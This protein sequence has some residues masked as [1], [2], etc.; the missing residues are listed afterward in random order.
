MRRRAA[1]YSIIRK[2]ITNDNSAE[3]IMKT[4]LLFLLC[5]VL[6]FMLLPSRADSCA[7]GC[8]VF[9]VGTRWMMVTSPGPRIFVQ[10]S[11]LDQ[12]QN[13][14]NRQQVSPDLNADKLIRTSFYTLGM[15]YMLN[16]EWGFMVETQLW[17]RYRE[18]LDD[19]DKPFTVR[20]VALG[21]TRLMAMYTG[22]SEDMSTGFSAGIKLPTGPINQTLLDRDTQVGTGTTD[23]LFSAYQMGQEDGW[24]W[25][26]QGAVS[27]PLAEHD[28]YKPGNDFN[29]AIGAHYDRLN[30]SSSIIPIASVVA[31]IRGADGGSLADPENTGYSRIFF[32]PGVEVLFGD[33][34][35]F[36][37]EFGIPIYSNIR[38][39]QLI[40]PW[41]LNTTV[42][43]QF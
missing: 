6:C 3:R 12:N 25:F 28:G 21:D 22:L 11:F 30:S 23:A 31:S 16:R 10:Y 17:D 41:L 33:G 5:A 39:Y 38:G 35:H 32:S 24:G 7:C 18:G 27:F 42:S 14:S 2:F 19:A 13:W 40:S 26:I 4:T 43:Y 8:G 20:H 36:D 9:Q 37:I 1:E 34:F 29:G 15:Q